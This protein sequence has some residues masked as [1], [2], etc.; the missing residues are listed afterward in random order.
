MTSY[1]AEDF[2][3]SILLSPSRLL[4]KLLVVCPNVDYCEEVLTRCE[5][6]AHLLHR[7]RGAVTRCI[8]SSLGCSFQGPR[9]ALQSHLWECPYRD[10]NAGKNPVTEGEVS[11]IEVQRKE[12]ENLG[13]G[14]VGGCDTPL[15]C[16]VIQEVFADGA[17]S[18][19]GRLIAGDQILEVNGE[20]LTQATHH[21][22]V[23]ILAQFF[24]VCRLTVYR[25]RAEESRPI[26]KEEILKITLNKIKGRQL[27][28]KLVGKRNGPGVYIL[29]LIPGS[30]AACDGR[31]KMDDR[32]L[33]I[34]GQDVS[35]G[36]QEQSASII[37][38]SPSR[39]QFVV[40]RRSRP[41]TPDIIRSAAEHSKYAAFTDDHEKP[42]SPL[43]YTCKE[44]I[45]TI[46]K[47]P[48]E[49]L[50]IS[51][52]GGMTSHRGDTPVYITNIN[53]DG[54]VGRTNVLKKG[55]VLVSINSTSLLNLTHLESVKQIRQSS[56]VK[57]LTLRVIDCRETSQGDHNF[58]PS[59]IYWLQMPQMLR[60]V[61]TITL[62]RSPSG[63]LGFSI[64]GG[65]DCSHGNL[66]IIV[67]SVVPDTPAAKDG[68]LRCGDIL[69]AVNEHN[70]RTVNQAAAVE[71]LKHI[72]GAVTLSVV[73]WPGTV[74]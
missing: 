13:I 20:D 24:P 49:T 7:C 10:Q 6:E 30:L 15:V 23:A 32:V 4:D 2:H 41:Q 53:P 73:S 63:S 62:L 16:T 64:V 48:S 18:H 14:V 40:A 36:T 56:E 25:E 26:E 61:R 35:Y 43:C 9:S 31:L 33:E 68:R 21:Q 38:N 3:Y 66:P 72:D 34:N 19:D 67:K 17:V 52:A 44:K 27:G 59:W 60:M 45:V 8:K 37:V 71:I 54:C 51:I 65:V 55:D 50:G 29:T 46:N 58:T 22:A 69:L 5:L 70:L 74:V 11:T 1:T 57:V 47:D 28:I 39:V 42:V 12:G